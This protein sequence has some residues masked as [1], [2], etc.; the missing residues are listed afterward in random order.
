MIEPE[1]IKIAIAKK[2]LRKLKYKTRLFS[3]IFP[4][5]IFLHFVGETTITELWRHTSH[6]TTSRTLLNLLAKTGLFEIKKV[7]QTK[8]KTR[9]YI[10][11]NEKGKKFAEI[12]LEILK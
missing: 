9:I 5:I 11:L 3:F 10:S 6:R 1:K 4:A 2:I 7:R 8:R 12:L